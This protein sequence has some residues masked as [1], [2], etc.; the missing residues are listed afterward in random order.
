M[1][2]SPKEV[3]A[4]HRT[5]PADG[6][7][8]G[9]SLSNSLLRS[10]LIFLLFF[11]SALSVTAQQGIS[12]EDV[13][14]ME[15]VISADISDD[16]Q[17][18]AYTKA[19]PANPYEEN[20]PA[21]YHLYLYSL[22]NGTAIPFITRTTVRSVSFRP[23]TDAITFLAKLEGDRNTAL[24]Q[25]SLRGGEA[26]KIY[27]HETAISAYAWSADGS[28]LA[29]TAE[30]PEGEE[31]KSVD[32]PYEPIVY[33][34]NP[35]YS[36]GYIMEW[37]SR[38]PKR[39]RLPGDYHSMAWSPD[40]KR[41]AVAT[42]P[43]P[44][45]DDFY[46][47]QRIQILDAESLEKI[48]EVDHAGKLDHFAWSP[49]GELL[50]MIAGATIN[51]PIAGRLFVVDKDGGEPQILRP[52]AEW[53]FDDF[54]WS[55]DG[56]IMFV[57]SEGVHSFM[58]TMDA[59]GSDLKRHDKT[60]GL[61]LESMDLASNGAMAFTASS[62]QFPSEAFVVPADMSE[63]QRITM[64][65]PWLA[66]RELAKQEVITYDARD[67][68][69]IQGILMHPLNKETGK[70]YPLITVV[71]GGPESHY[72]NGWLTQYSTAG[73]M[74]AA[75]GYYVFYPNYRGST[76]RGVA[77]AMSSQGDPAGAEFDD[78]VD[79]VDYLID[80]YDIDEEKVGVTGGSYGGYATGWMATKYTD[81]F[82]AGVMFV[83]ISNNISKWG[84][85]DIPEELYL[86]HARKRIWED[87]QFF[88]ERSPIYYADQSETPLLIMTGAEDTRVD[89]S[90]S[91]ELYRHLRTRT[92]TPVRLVLYPG[93]GHG[94]RKSSARLD[95]SLRML[96]W[97]NKYLK[98]SE[99]DYA[100]P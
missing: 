3:G 36:V 64:S 47:K 71:H 24:Y 19:V 21:S 7:Q 46:M 90:Q 95:Y 6:L 31:E 63:A 82:A 22:E 2:K 62:G 85:T 5:L 52:A 89:P 57:A 77:F 33:E 70:S 58:G 87:Y 74:A 45:V 14:K 100:K 8:A 18:V 4:P 65:N 94:N 1:K 55:G 23:G 80:N 73:Q 97:F 72:D 96:G 43:T 10:V 81:R 59:D 44:F 17:H 25:M 32:L 83:G 69:E 68:Q 75:E 40:G 79:G 92:D 48:G 34:E 53:K 93:E 29:F 99:S 38:E 88:L 86:V 42:S 20:R 84:T 98:G 78:I 16:G 11:G 91:V 37:D 49:D 54:A 66:E 56:E 61:N 28:H 41:I 9:R 50:G 51:D 60:E 12:P 26:Q 15:T 27:E 76:G 35:S 67:G 30:G 39:M 13:A